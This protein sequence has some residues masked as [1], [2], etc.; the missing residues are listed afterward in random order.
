MAEFAQRLR[1]DLADAFS[2]DG[3]VLADLFERVLAAVR[4]QAEAHLD[5]LLLARRQRL[6]N[7]LRDFAEVDVDDSLGR[8]LDGLVLD[9]VAEVR[10]FLFADRRLQRNRLLG[11]LED[12]PD[13][14]GRDVHLF[15]DLFRGRLAAQLL[16]ERARG[17]DQLVD[18]F[19]H[20]HRDADGAGLIGDGSRDRLANPPRRVSRELVTAPVLELV[21][22]LHQ[23][24]VAFLDQVEE[25]QSAV[26]V[27]LRDRDHQ[28]QVGFDQFLLGLLR[29]GVAHHHSLHGAFDLDRG[30]VV[31]PF[32]LS[33]VALGG[34]QSLLGLLDL[35]G[36]AL[37]LERAGEL[38][39]LLF[40]RKYVGPGLLHRVDQPVLDLLR[41]IQQPDELRKLDALPREFAPHPGEL[42]RTLRLGQDFLVKRVRL[43]ERLADLGDGF[44]GVVVVLLDLLFRDAFLFGEGHD[45]AD[46]KVAVR[47]LVAYPE[48]LGDGDGRARDRLLHSDL[49]ALDALCDGDFAFSRQQWHHAHLA[50]VEADRVVRFVQRPRREIQ[51]KLLLLRL[52]K[53]LFSRGHGRGGFQKL[54]FRITNRY[55]LAAQRG[56][57]VFDVVRRD[58]ALRQLLV[59]VVVGQEGLLLAHVQKFLNIVCVF[60]VQFNH[61]SSLFIRSLRA[62][63]LE[64]RV[65][66]SLPLTVLITREGRAKVLA[67]CQSLRLPF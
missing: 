62:T 38:V 26:G 6:Q 18:R 55:P 60:L 11:D 16:H 7:L 67:Y 53:L 61:L 33:E 1:L 42:R 45:L 64:G 19:D 37:A 32:E 31:L 13:L 39:D 29:F 35:L 2:R 51:L 15:G 21:D 44:E 10:I 65:V 49:A 66:R 34:A 4:A 57:D 36:V 52:L 30:L 14:R 20:V 59:D 27:F 5:D 48:Q 23:A 9:E 3:E 8:V 63:S 17:A 46:R 28:S 22:G 25:L 50:Q 56:E 24:D 12:L 41:E 47:Q 40:G 43:L 58:Q 54:L